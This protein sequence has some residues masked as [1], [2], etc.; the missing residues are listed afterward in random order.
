MRSGILF[1]RVSLEK[2]KKEKLFTRMVLRTREIEQLYRNYK[3]Y[4]LINA[5]EYMHVLSDSTYRRRRSNLKKLLGVLDNS[6]E[7][8]F[9]DF[10]NSIV[11]E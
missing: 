5:R 6:N 9:S 10:I 7:Y 1:I 4:E 8:S 2:Q 11:I 3:N